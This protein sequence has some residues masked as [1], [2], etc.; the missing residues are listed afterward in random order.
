MISSH[1]KSSS[2][3]S[4]A[5]E[6]PHFLKERSTISLE[7]SC[8]DSLTHWQTVTRDAARSWPPGVNVF[9]PLII[10]V[11]HFSHKR[12]LN[13]LF[14]QTS[15]GWTRLVR[16][17]SITAV[18]VLFSRSCCFTVSVRW[19]LNESQ[20]S[21]LWVFA[22]PPGRARQTFSIQ[23]LTPLSSMHPFGWLC[24]TMPAGKLSF[25]IVFRLKMAI[26]FSLVPS[27]RHASTTVKRV[28]SWP[29]VFRRTVLAPTESTV[30]DVGM[31]NHTGVSSI[32]PMLTRHNFIYLER[33]VSNP[34][35]ACFL[36]WTKITFWPLLTLFWS[37]SKVTYVQAGVSFD[38]W[39]GAFYF[40]LGQS[41]LRV[42]CHVFHLVLTTL[43]SST[44][45]NFEKLL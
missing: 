2:V 38:Q 17:P 40:H 13:G 22:N 37:N 15:R 18:A 42:L 33:N 14:K 12:S 20:T 24:T 26:G 25:G 32:F 1:T 8:H 9:S 39:N 43:S 27:A 4:R 11:I 23:I 35:F 16:P 7:S 3:L 44:A 36:C 5:F 28:F 21:K 29:V 10:Q 6:I 19:A 34:I 30:L 31:S 41:E 45:C